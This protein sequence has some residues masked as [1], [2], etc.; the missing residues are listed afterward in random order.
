MKK[1]IYLLIGLVAIFSLIPVLSAKAN[2]ITT[3]IVTPT[4]VYGG[5]VS[6]Y[7]ISFVVASSTEI[8]SKIVL[9]FPGG[10]NVANAATSTAST[11]DGAG[12]GVL[13][14]STIAG[15]VI[16][17]Q[18]AGN[19]VD[20][21]GETVE[22]NL[23]SIVNPYTGGSP[24]I[25]VATLTE[26]GGA[27]DSGTSA[28]FNITPGIQPL[29]SSG[30]RTPPNSYITSPTDGLTIPVGEKYTIKGTAQDAGGS[31]VQKVE[32]SL[33]GGNSW[34]LT[35]IKGALENVFSWEYVW[36]NPTKG[37]YVI[38]VRAT[39]AVGNI[40]SPSVGVKVTVAVPV[41]ETPIEVPEKPIIEM[42]VPELEAKITEIQQKIIDILEQIIQLFQ[43]QIQALLAK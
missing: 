18:L 27:I 17:L 20:P 22:V 12:D 8:E 10:F 30:D 25:T 15:Q 13:A 21:A 29:S 33:D 32:I 16:T 9:T 28:A 5:Y 40:A 6:D 37:E 26:N 4:N 23:T 24:T 34:F 43:Q 42:T 3:L 14:S 41:P 35:E 1:E 39:D 2:D 11:T 36:Q 31:S 19:G 38:K 7:N